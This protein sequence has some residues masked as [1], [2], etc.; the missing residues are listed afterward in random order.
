MNFNSAA[1]RKYRP[2]LPYFLTNCNISA[3]AINVVPDDWMADRGEVHANLM[4]ATGLDP[5]FQQ[6]EIANLSQPAIRAQR[7]AAPALLDAHPRPHRGMA[8]DVERNLAGCLAQPAVDQRE[9]CL[10]DHSILKRLAQ[11]RMSPVVLCD[12]QKPGSPFVD[13]VD[14]PRPAF[15]SGPGQILKLEQQ[16][17][18]QRVSLRTCTRM[19]HETGRLFDNSQ[20]IVFVN[21]LEWNILGLQPEGWRG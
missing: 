8:S 10:F 3:L 7:H 17:V 11:P 1:W 9:V 18:D 15:P 12:D 20:V 2:G 4:R 13:P 16:A 5:H 19:H 21:D 14:N 6:G